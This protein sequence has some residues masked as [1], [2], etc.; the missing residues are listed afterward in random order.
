MRATSPASL[1]AFRSILVFGVVVASPVVPPVC[2]HDHYSIRAAA[3]TSLVS[4]G[5]Y[6]RE[7][8]DPVLDFLTE[9]L[10]ILTAEYPHHYFFWYGNYYAAQAFFHADH[11]LRKGCFQRYFNEISNHLI[12]DQQEDGRWLNPR[13]EGPGDAFG[14][15]VACI[16]LQIPNQYLPIFLR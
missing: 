1:I 16:I 3:V 6:K 10:P 2:K 4:A 11:L 14:T 9:E 5:V 7:L 8:I 12:D 15:A 13:H